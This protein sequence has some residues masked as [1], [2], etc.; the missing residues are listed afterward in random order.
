VLAFLREHF[1]KAE[2]KIDLFHLFLQRAVSFLRQG[3][4]LGYIVPTS[5]LNNFYAETLRQWLLDQC[6]VERIAVSRNQVFADA[7]VHTTI[8]VLRREENK[9]QRDTHE[10][11]ITDDFPEKAQQSISY[12]RALQSRFLKIPGCVWNILLNEDNANL[13][14]HL[15]KDSVSLQKVATINR[16]LITGNRE[17][18]FSPTRETEDHVEIIEG[19]DVHRYFVTPPSNFVLFKRPESAG[20]CWDRDVHFAPH[21]IVIRQISEAPTASLVQKPLAVTGNIFT[22][23][24]ASEEEELYL[25]G[26]INS[27]LTGFFWKTM[28]A[29]FKTSFPQVTVFSLE[30]LPIKQTEKMSK[31]NLAVKKNLITGVK[32]MLD[33]QKAFHNLPLVLEKKIHHSNRTPCNLAHYLQQDFAEEVKAEILIDDVQRTGFVHEITV[34]PEGRNLTL[35]AA[36]AENSDGEP[37]PMPVLQLAFEEDA[38][39]QFIYACWRRFLGEHSRQKKWT[40]G[41]KPEPVYSLLVNT[42]EPLVYFSPAAVDNLRAIRDLMKAV[43]AEA[44][45]ADLAAL[46][47][48]IK[49]LDFAIDAF[50]YELYGLTEAEIRIVEEAAK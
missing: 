11:L 44:G 22:I 32:A 38:M 36:V 1:V 14:T 43:A 31:R 40:K 3:S 4:R 26:V 46:E 24:A 16:G 13:V 49:K 42:L 50:V 2:F 6:C 8:L 41:K 45:S 9:S 28:F 34:K 35:I 7:D 37:L 29:D 33:A 18:F 15:R 10:I 12:S 47:S 27:R 21:K 39:R 48:E 25:L 23:M 30:Q 5:I 20:G 19:G 17:R